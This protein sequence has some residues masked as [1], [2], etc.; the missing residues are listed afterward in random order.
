MAEHKPRSGGSPPTASAALVRSVRSSQ[1]SWLGGFAVQ[2]G[3][4]FQL[5]A[6]HFSPAPGRSTPPA[7][8]RC[9]RSAPSERS[10]SVGR[11]MWR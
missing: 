6:A 8:V 11:E 7:L 3:C 2:Q 4:A 9:G 1:L 10:S 5:A